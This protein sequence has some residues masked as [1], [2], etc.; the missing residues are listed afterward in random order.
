[1]YDFL[2]KLTELVVVNYLGHTTNNKYSTLK[3]WRK[4]CGCTLFTNPHYIISKVKKTML[5]PPLKLVFYFYTNKMS[6]L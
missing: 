2:W 5:I 3:H 4:F 6:I 1:M